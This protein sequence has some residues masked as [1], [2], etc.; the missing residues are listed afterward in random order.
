MDELGELVDLVIDHPELILWPITTVTATVYLLISQYLAHKHVFWSDYCPP[1]CVVVLV[2]NTLWF[3]DPR[4]EFWL[5]L[6]RAVV[7][8]PIKWLWSLFSSKNW[9]KWWVWRKK[10]LLLPEPATHRRKKRI[11]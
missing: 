2:F 9:R 8:A 5:S 3:I 11:W 10:E 7:E 4:L 6:P 1:V